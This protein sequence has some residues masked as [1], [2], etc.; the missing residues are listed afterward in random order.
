MALSLSDVKKAK[1]GSTAQKKRVKKVTREPARRPWD[2]P[3][4]EPTSPASISQA[5]TDQKFTK[6]KKSRG[7]K[8]Q[9]DSTE[10]SSLG[11]GIPLSV[12]EYFSALV[13]LNRSRL[14]EGKRPSLLLPFGYRSKQK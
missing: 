13:A 2:A 14:K 5:P 10:S 8:D 9:S 11:I 12:G 3:V 1:S 7:R 6:I 4:A